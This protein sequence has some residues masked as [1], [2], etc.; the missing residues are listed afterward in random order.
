MGNSW[1]EQDSR[2][3]ARRQLILVVVA[4]VVVRLVYLFQYIRSPYFG[5]HLVDQTYYRN[6]AWR[7]AS[8]DWLGDAVF[9]QGPL[10]A[11]LSALVYRLGA[12]DGLVLLIQ[13][14]TGV[15]TTALVYLCTRR[16]AGNQTA[17][18]AGLMLAVCGPLVYYECMIMKTFLSPMFT[19]L[20]LYAGLRFTDRKEKKWIVFAGAIVGLA[21]LSRESHI[22][23]LAPLW[24]W[25]YLNR[26]AGNSVSSENKSVKKDS[27]LSDSQTLIAR[28]RPTIKLMALSAAACLIV[29][30]PAT[31]HN[32]VVAREFVLV[33]SGGGEVFYMAHGP[34]ATGN[35]EPPPFVRGNPYLEHEDFRYEA[36]KRL[37]HPVDRGE[38]SRYWAKQAWISILVDPG[39]AL[40]LTFNKL[41]GLFNDF[42]VPDSQTYTVTKEYISI[43][44]FLPSFGFYV[45][46]G[47]AGILVIRSH[48]RQ[49]VLPLGILAV[50]VISILL[51]YNFGRFRAGLIP[52]WVIF[53]AIG[54][55]W[56]W[57]VIVKD[58]KEEKLAVSLKCF[59]L[60]VVTG[61]AFMRPGQV[62]VEQVE[63]EKKKTHE[64]L[65]KL[66][67]L[68][69]KVDD[70]RAKLSA[71]PMSVQL[72]QDLGM[73]YIKMGRFYE[74]FRLFDQ[75][76]AIR[77]YDERVHLEYAEGL[78]SLAR[79]D[80][81]SEHYWKAVEAGSFEA[82]LKFGGMYAMAREW[83]DSLGQ[84]ER[85]IEIEP[86]RPEVHLNMGRVLM[87]VCTQGNVPSE[88]VY[89]PC[90][91]ALDSFSKAISLDP[92][93]EEAHVKRAMLL[94]FLGRP[95]EA[96]SGLN[97]AIEH[98]EG[99][100]ELES[101][102]DN[103]FFRG[104][105]NVT[106]S[107]AVLAAT[108]FER[109]AKRAFENKRGN[110]A[111]RLAEKGATLARVGG[112]SGLAS[113]L[114]QAAKQYAEDLR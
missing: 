52:V 51:T 105:P 46:L 39:R 18:I 85:A 72:K 87:E 12:G 66:S 113:S 68:K 32:F 90:D 82:R 83:S 71:S 13:L 22:L 58:L 35:Y 100:Q 70:T 17:F 106:A 5:V 49:F 75:V 110:D 6:W 67:D 20:V 97:D 108:L 92:R 53:A 8:G 19:L 76:L 95:S 24:I 107:D 33:T 29:M 57:R 26:D 103:I 31:V 50:H 27:R 91:R 48:W 73:T 99:S 1:A 112:N 54:L 88:E 55:H 2:S 43:L 86:D 14:T 40:K 4:A 47:F 81:A 11:Y 59:V 61:L 28:W 7:I 79:F 77:P 25:V 69:S 15:A 63:L 30:L 64:T 37:K 74:A 45:G 84:L 111:K 80:L 60:I 44:R 89:R 56:L 3:S 34:Y 41:V 38:S 78:A 9:E 65:Q 62:S 23:L 109:M 102:L 114:D 101:L 98:V 21:C 42:E 36:E 104:T 94:H 96:V 16:L 10:Y 93:Q